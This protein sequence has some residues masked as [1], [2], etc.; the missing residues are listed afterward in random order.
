MKFTIQNNQEALLGLIIGAITAIVGS[1]ILHLKYELTEAI[2]VGVI[3]GL[4][5]S[6]ILSLIGEAIFDLGLGAIGGI[7]GAILSLAFFKQ[8]VNPSISIFL[9]GIFGILIASCV[10]YLRFYWLAPRHSNPAQKTENSIFPGQPGISTRLPKQPIPQ[11]G[12]QRTTPINKTLVAIVL[13]LL[14]GG[15]IALFQNQINLEVLVANENEQIVDDAKVTIFYEGGKQAQLT[16]SDGSSQF[17]IEHEENSG[18]TVFIEAEGYRV[19]QEQIPFSD[20]SFNIEDLVPRLDL[21]SIKRILRVE[22]PNM[23]DIVFFVVD[24]NGFP[25]SNADVSLIVAGDI[26]RE[27]SNEYGVAVFEQI[28]VVDGKIEADITVVV[29]GAEITTHVLTLLSNKI[30]T[31]R[32]NRELQTIQLSLLA[33]PE[34]IEIGRSVLGTPIEAIRFG[35]GTKEIIFVGGLHAGFAPGTVQLAEE[36]I[37]YFTNNPDEIPDNITLYIISEVNPDSASAPGQLNGRLNTN[38]VD[39][40]RNWDCRWTED[41]SFRGAPI[42]GAGGDDP[43]SESETQA[44]RDFIEKITPEGVVFWLARADGGLSSP[45]S[46]LQTHNESIRLADI[47]GDAAN[48]NVENFETRNGL[49]NGDASNSLAGNGIP[50]ISI[51]LPDYQEIDWENNL[52]GILAVL[53]AY[54]D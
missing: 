47:Y 4:F 7:L 39:L 11:R 31:L 21:I 28:P 35:V 24:Q 37:D 38:G 20:G 44:L 12:R 2:L 41:P 49:V 50:A 19:W 6:I 42:E 40:N 36:S 13:L 1:G 53:E 17:V 14:M 43:F 26:Y 5:S 16:G 30:Q 25:L 29:E 9:G 33:G 54:S 18:G 22:T 34:T 27:Y 8:F 3:I 15:G 23:G 10:L 46:C 51:L 52:D 48:Y 32:I 45:G